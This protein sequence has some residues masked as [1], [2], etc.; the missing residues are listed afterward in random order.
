MGGGVGVEV[1]E[2][3]IG[4]EVAIEVVIEA[5]VKVGKTETEMIKG[6]EEKGNRGKGVKKILVLGIN[7]REDHDLEQD[8]DRDQK[9]ETIITETRNHQ[10][11]PLKGPDRELDPGQDHLEKRVLEVCTEDVIP[12]LIL[13][14]SV[15]EK[16]I[17]QNAVELLHST[18]PDQDREH[19][20]S[21]KSTTKRVNTGKIIT[22]QEAGVAVEVLKI[23][24]IERKILEKMSRIN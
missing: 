8:R 20:L 11:D 23:I 9:T 5:E 14:S 6:I 7:H 17:N 1:V 22:F 15:V 13:V 19:R 18:V 3:G 2:I 24:K 21:A 10:K 12:D 16:I 4:I